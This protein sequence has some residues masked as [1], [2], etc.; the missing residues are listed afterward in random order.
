MDLGINGRI[1]LITGAESGIGFSTAEQLL[2]EGA[3]VVITDKNQSSLDEAARELGH[4]VRA[5]AADLTDPATVALLKKRVLGEVGVP[6]ILVNAAGVTGATG[7]FHEIDEQGWIDTLN[8][9]LMSPVRLVRAFIDED[10]VQPCVD[11]LPYCAAKAG[12][13]SLAKGLSKTYGKEGVLVNAVSPAFIAT[14]MTDAMMDK[15]AMEYGTSFDDAV[16][17]FLDEER[18]FMELRRRGKAEEVAAV[19]VFLCSER[20]SFVNGSNYRV[21]SGSVATI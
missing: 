15:R 10:A 1:A 16:K 7:M 17:S 8:T 14:P 3:Q 2:A 4:G 5:F 21:D 13:L 6:Q 11:E 9:D 18:P 12:V 19:V 20:A